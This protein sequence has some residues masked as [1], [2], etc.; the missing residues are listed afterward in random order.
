MALFDD[1]TPVSCSARL[2]QIFKQSDDRGLCRLGLELAFRL[3]PSATVDNPEQQDWVKGLF[4]Q[5]TFG[6]DT[7]GIRDTFNLLTTGGWEKVG[8]SELDREV[9]AGLLTVVAVRC[10]A[11]RSCSTRSRWGILH[12]PQPSPPP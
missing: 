6:T 3:S 4:P 8:R 12:G 2:C 10:R 7:K 1:D 11:L 9:V 5:S